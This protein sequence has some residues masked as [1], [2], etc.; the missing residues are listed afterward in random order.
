MDEH[1]SPDCYDDPDNVGLMC[2]L[3]MG[4]YRDWTVWREGQRWHARHDTWP[5]DV[6]LTSPNTELL[7][8]TIKLIDEQP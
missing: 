1:K 3:L 6:A 8:K 7:N 5:D 2:Q 4:T